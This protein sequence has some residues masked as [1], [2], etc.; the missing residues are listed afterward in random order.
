MTEKAYKHPSRGARL[1]A[2]IIQPLNIMVRQCGWCNRLLGFRKG[3][4]GVTSGMCEACAVRW[5]EE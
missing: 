1:L 4:K 3:G 5:S 2:F